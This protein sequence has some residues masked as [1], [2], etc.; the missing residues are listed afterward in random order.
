VPVDPMTVTAHL[1]DRT[2]S[3]DL[4][5]FGLDDPAVF[6]ATCVMGPAELRE[7]ADGSPVVTDDRPILEYSAPGAVYGGSTVAGNID[8]IL[9]L[10]VPAGCAEQ[11]FG[12]DF[13]RAWDALMLFEEAEA[14]RDR[15]MIPEETRLLTLAISVCPEFRLAGSRLAA[16]LHQ[17]ASL[18]MERGD[19]QGA[20]ELIQRALA[21]GY[22]D[23][24]L[25]TY[26]AA[27]E[28]SMGYF[29]QAAEHASMA[30][31]SEPGS[32]A[33][34]TAYGKALLGTGDQEGARSA[35]RLADSL[36]IN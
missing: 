25:L 34:L 13:L 9:S 14:A 8:A 12:N 35:L 29:T 2:V 7:Y 15:G 6:L 30:L 21:T 3:A 36:S 26:L 19:G 31:Q 23:A 24:M 32:V 22:G 11:S 16:S 18:S 5:P 10:A 1:S 33:A 4:A 20:W 27:M 28:V 17:S